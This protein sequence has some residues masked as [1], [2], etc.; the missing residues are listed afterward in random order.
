MSPSRTLQESLPG[1][2]HM[3]VFLRPFLARQRLLLTTSMLALFCEVGMGTLE[4][5]PLKFI[6]D[7]VLGSKKRGGSRLAQWVE[8]LDPATVVMLAVLALVVISALRSLVDFISTVGFAR[9]ANRVLAEVRGKLYLHLQALSLSFHTRSR[10]GDLLLRV[11]ADVNQLR[12]VAVTAALPLFADALVLLGM[13]AVMF[14]LHWKL[15]LVSLATLPF[16]ALWTWRLTREIR[17][18]ARTQR[19]RESAM[20]AMAAESLGAIK[21]VQA[22]SLEERFADRFL[23][24]NHESQNQDVRTARLTAALG[25]SVTFLIAASTALVLWYGTKLVIRQE[26]SP[27]ELLVFVTYLKNAFRPVRDFAKYT[28]RIVKAAASGERVLS[29]LGQTPEIQ[30]TPASLPAP[31][32]RGAVEFAGVGFAYEPGRKVLQ[33][34]DFSVAPGQHVALVGRSGIGKSTIASLLLRLHDPITGEVR[35]DGRDVRDFTLASLRSQISVVLQDS[36]LFAATIAE[37][38][39]YGTVDASP[40]AINAAARVAG[41]HEFIIALPEGYDTMVGE[42][43]STLS[44]GQRQRIAIARAAIR[45]APILIFDEATTG[46]DSENERIVLEAL[47]RL[48]R[49]RTTFWITHDLDLA[50]R[51]N[52]IVYLESGNVLERGTH[53]ELMDRGGRYA[54]LYSLQRAIGN[55]T[56]ALHESARN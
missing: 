1:L 11:M 52:L 56:V 51:A 25:R 9:I 31:R 23:R 15:A 2:R 45:K 40:A 4:P 18:S 42:R 37:N 48:S 50:S 16:F 8:G 6:F 7:Q 34:I 47:L 44:G 26:L 10:G 53:D 32:F 38:I 14:W 3:A 35:I 12:D 33:K 41:A 24:R 49:D 17:R 39:A 19:Q 21:L 46:L 43:G 36:I 13:I 54:S 29:L 20:A 55:R 28:G 22:L 30:D 27:G 5:W